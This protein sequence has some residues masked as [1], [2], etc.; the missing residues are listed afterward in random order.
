[1]LLPE[2][3]KNITKSTF[4]NKTT[5]LNICFT[6][7]K[8][9][10]INKQIMQANEKAKKRSGLT[11]P[12]L[13]YDKNSQT[14]ILYKGTPIIAR[15]NEK[16]YDICN[17]ETFIIKKIG[18][19]S[20]IIE[21]EDDDETISRNIEIPIKYFQRL[22]YVAYCITT[23]RSQ[24]STFTNAYTIHEFDLFDNR[25]KYVALSRSTSINNI[26]IV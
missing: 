16:K 6:N 5:D 2:N 4:G 23:H 20:I 13:K 10:E 3:I 22:F 8:R 14:T 12:K 7:K 9:I 18:K 19:D 25:L 24:G 26:N 1:M 15:I 21:G 17:N 11:L